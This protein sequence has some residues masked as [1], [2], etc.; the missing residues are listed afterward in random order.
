MDLS[1]TQVFHGDCL[2]LIKEIPDASVDA[3]VSYPPYGYLKH[4]PDRPFDE[5]TL[6]AEFKRILKP[7]GAIVLFGRGVP[8]SDGAGVKMIFY[9]LRN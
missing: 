7:A 4:R 3:V 5:D 1:T 6:F 2:D 9:V 8:F